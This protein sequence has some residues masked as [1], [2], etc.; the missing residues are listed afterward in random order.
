MKIL[1]L[2]SINVGPVIAQ[3]FKK[4]K[5]ANN[6]YFNIKHG[7]AGKNLWVYSCGLHSV[8]FKPANEKD[9]L[10]L[11]GDNYILRPIKKRV[12][13]SEDDKI[14]L[15]DKIGNTLYS[16]SIDNMRHHKKDIILFWEIPNNNYTDVS[17][18]TSGNVSELGKGWIGKERNEKL[19]SSPAPVLEIQG[20]CSL[21]WVA[22][23]IDGFKIKQTIKYDFEKANWDISPIKR[24]T[25]GDG[26][27]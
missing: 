14:V 21:E 22:V 11:S 24:I 20:N 7:S 23:D 13:G 6:I 2:T 18:T 26:N 19:Y 10:E 12:G 9:S 3:T 27:N 4:S 1:R 16:I 25:D 15:K 8:H 17:Y 5:D